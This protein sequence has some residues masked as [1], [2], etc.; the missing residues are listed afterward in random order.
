[1]NDPIFINFFEEFCQKQ[2]YTEFYLLDAMGS[3]LFLDDEA[4]PTFLIVKDEEGMQ[5]DYEMMDMNDT[6]IHND[7]LMA[8]KNK[9]KLLYFFD[10]VAQKTDPNTWGII[11]ACG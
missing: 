5:A 10:R 6:P 3:F 1:M 7:L 11:Y 2:K 8:V 9:E 4:N